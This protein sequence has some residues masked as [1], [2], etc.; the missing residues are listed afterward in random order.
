[1]PR[2][3]R[4]PSPTAASL[5]RRID[6]TTLQLFIAVCEETNL[7][8]AAQREGIAASAVSKRLHD[9][10]E[11]LQ[12]TLFERQSSGMALTPAGESLL[13]HARV[14]LINIEKIAVELGEHARGVR[15]HVRMFANLSAIVEFL[16]DDLPSFFK[17]HDLVR[18]DLQERPSADVV[19]GVEEG[20]AEIGICSADV[21]TR[22]LERHSYRRD[23][24]VAIVPRDHTLARESHIAFA[25]T[26]DYD[27]VGLF[28]TSSIYLRSHHSALQA[29][30]TLK[31][32]V[33][34]PGFDAVCR[35]VQAGMGVGLIPDKAFDV[36]SHGMN[37]KAITLDD[38]WADRELILV[39][40]DSAKLST[41]SQMM[42]D[43][44]LH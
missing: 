42:F 12:V 24:L 35:M 44:L 22:G 2:L 3:P 23:R 21:E 13:H 8:R 39:A 41:T 37:L 6:L 19:R 9:L 11:T 5:V 28:A 27:H 18:L 10:E 43:H 29:G 26:L 40:R 15:G 7:T 33:H 16:P 1:M 20:S 25:D 14:T 4:S 17:I 36:L 31:L 34:V 30:K 32:R 38:V